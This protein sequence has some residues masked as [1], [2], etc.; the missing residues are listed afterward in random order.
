MVR[1][2]DRL[3]REELTGAGENRIT[4]NLV[5]FQHKRVIRSVEHFMG[6]TCVTHG[7]YK[8]SIGKSEGKSRL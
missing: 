4:N 7:T 3:K 1:R 8:T 5:T 6:Y 2:T